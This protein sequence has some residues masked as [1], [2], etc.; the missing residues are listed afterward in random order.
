MRPAVIEVERAGDWMSAEELRN[1][2]LQALGEGTDVTLN[3]DKVDHLDASALQI[4]LALDTEQKKNGRHLHLA[5]ASSHLRQWLDYAGASD[6]FVM[7]RLNG[8]E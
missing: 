6:H 8:D 7:T 2:S 4:L 3:L 5:N 1:A